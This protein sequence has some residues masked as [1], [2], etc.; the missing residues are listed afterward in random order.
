MAIYSYVSYTPENET[1]WNT[2]PSLTLSCEENTLPSNITINSI[3]LNIGIYGKGTGSSSFRAR[4]NYCAVKYNGNTICSKDEITESNKTTTVS[5][6]AELKDFDPTLTITFYNLN[7][8]ITNTLNTITVLTQGCA[9]DISNGTTIRSI[10]AEIFYTPNYTDAPDSVESNGY[11]SDYPFAGEPNTTDYGILT[12]EGT[13]ESSTFNYTAPTNNN[14]GISEPYKLVYSTNNSSSANYTLIGDFN[15]CKNQY[16]SPLSKGLRFGT[17]YY[18]RILAKSS[19]HNGFIKSDY[20]SVIYKSNITINNISF[21][22]KYATPAGTKIL[23]NIDVSGVEG[24]SFTYKIKG[25]NLEEQIINQSTELTLYPGNYIITVTDNYGGSATNTISISTLDN[26]NIIVDDKTII[27]NRDTTSIEQ[28]LVKNIDRLEPTGYI[29]S[30]QTPSIPYEVKCH[31]GESIDDLTYGEINIGTAPYFIDIDVGE[32]VSDIANNGLWYNFEI[33]GSYTTNGIE[34]TKTVTYG[35]FKYPKQLTDLTT[36]N[37]NIYNNNFTSNNEY[38]SY[39]IYNDKVYLT[40]TYPQ[41]GTEEYSKINKVNVY[42]AYSEKENIDMSYLL[43]NEFNATS[44]TSD[45]FEVNIKDIVPY[46]NYFKLYLELVTLTGE[47]KYIEIDKSTISPYDRLKRTFLPYFDNNIITSNLPKTIAVKNINTNLIL[48]IP[49]IYS[50]NNIDGTDINSIKILL[51]KIIF[52]LSIN[53]SSYDSPILLSNWDSFYYDSSKKSL[54][55]SISPSSLLTMISNSGVD[56]TENT[57]YNAKIVFQPRDF[58]GNTTEQIFLVNSTNERKGEY[59]IFSLGV[60]PVLS[61][62][63]SNYALKAKIPYSSDVIFNITNT[64]NEYKNMVNPKDILYLTFPAA[65]DD[66]GNDSGTAGNHGDI[67]GYKIKIQESANT[68]FNTEEEYFKD[69]DILTVDNS[70]LKYDNST[71]L[72]TYSYIIPDRQYSSFAKFA[73][74]AYDTTNLESNYY[75]YEPIIILGKINYGAAAI[76]NYKKNKTQDSSPNYNLTLKISDIGGNT[77]DN[78]SYNYSTYPNLERNITGNVNDSR[79]VK[80][81]LYYHT[82]NNSNFIKYGKELTYN[83]NNTENTYTS[84]DNT[85]I[86][87]SLIDTPI[88]FLNIDFSNTEVNLNNKNYFKFV[89][90]VQ[91]GFDNNGNKTYTTIETDT[92]IIFPVTPVMY[93][94][95]NAAGINTQELDNDKVLRI[96][97]IEQ[98][99]SLFQIDSFDEQSSVIFNLVSKI[100]EGITISDED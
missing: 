20:A 62:T 56:T 40:L 32:L 69:F 48:T 16:F 55:L 14:Y 13:I 49:T 21:S 18:Y 64:A 26:F 6:I 11:L 66:N 39:N 76:T 4:M 59:I 24:A 33:T 51:S 61:S 86:Y 35:P 78:K 12:V 94:G 9:P 29:G 95:K 8:K 28:G 84:Y 52:R 82:E 53:D 68:S 81:S 44:L 30:T 97:T 96:A 41:N 99:K 38:V 65:T 87:S 90:E 19:I 83:I 75:I 42:V 17:T 45:Q 3:T 50:I 46:N 92:F 74:C 77:F 63:S 58:F 70:N 88:N 27:S 10:R 98:E 31:Y 73:I 91:N 22:P 43:I 93:F 79:D 60:K 36:S 5:A 25:N 67:I 47:K 54:I 71:G 80:F 72:Y 1:L 57:S 7:Y 100:I 37:Y 85:I 34:Q 23:I 89:I 2:V 15:N